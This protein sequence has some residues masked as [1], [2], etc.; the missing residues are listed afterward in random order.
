MVFWMMPLELNKSLESCHDFDRS[1][2]SL[3][4]VIA[5]KSWGYSLQ[6]LTPETVI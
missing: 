4:G 1:H 5:V 3:T 6:S 2:V